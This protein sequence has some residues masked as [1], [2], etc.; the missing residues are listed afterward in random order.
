ANDF[1]LVGP[2]ADPAGIRGSDASAALRA[3]A[4]TR[5]PFV[6]RG[7][8][9][10]THVRERALWVDA[11]GLPIDTASWYM[12]IGQGMGN[13]LRIASERSGYTLTDRATFMSLAETLFLEVLVEGGAELENVYSVMTTARGR[14][15]RGAD[16]LAEWLASEPGQTLIGAFGV[17][18]FGRSLFEPRARQ[19]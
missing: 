18:R 4:A 6:S 5:A 14:N 13:A 7:D 11:G 16:A 2:A 8:D 10:G 17:E 9:S 15:G 19:P 12:S 3:I 1:V